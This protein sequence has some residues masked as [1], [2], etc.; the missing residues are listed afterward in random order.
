MKKVA[1]LLVLFFIPADFFAQLTV[2][3]SAAGRDNYIYSRGNLLYVAQ[4]VNLLKNTSGSDTE[5]SIYLRKEAQ[6][7]QGTSGIS[8]NT[9]DGKISVF[10]EGSS[11][12]YDYDYWASPVGENTSENGLFGLDL[13]HSPVNQTKS[14]KAEIISGL[15]G[16]AKPLQISSRWIYTYDGKNYSDWNFIGEKK[17]IP[18]GYGF[19][20]KGVNGI[21]PILV[22]GRENN[23][24]NSQRYDFRG[25]PN[26]GTI[27]IPVLEGQIVLVGNPYPSAL[28][29]SKFLLENS[30]S[31]SLTSECIGTITRKNA[32]TGI[33]YFWDS[34]ENG[35]SHYLKDYVGGYGAFSPVD[36]CTDGIYE[37]PIFI[38]YDSPEGTTTNLRGDYYERRYSPIGQGFMVEGAS[39]S[40][41]IFKNSQRVFKKE[42]E[43]SNP[44]QT[45]QKSPFGKQ[46]KSTALPKIQLEV[47]INDNY[48]RHLSLAFWKSATAGTDAAMDAKP[49]GSAATDVGFLH[50]DENFIID[51]RPFVKTDEIPLYLKV[52]E[53]PAIFKFQIV[54]T[55]NLEWKNFFLFDSKTGEYHSLSENPIE[56]S[57]PPGIYHNRFKLVFQKK[58]LETFTLENKILTEFDIFQNN[59][60]AQLEIRN[61]TLIPILSIGIYD[62][63]GRQLFYEDKLENKV[64]YSI[65]TAHFINS[66]YIVKIIK[67]N[68]TK[69]SKKITIL[70][71]R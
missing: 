36:P 2:K 15:E 28:D 59:D 34:Q 6:L 51:I 66:I 61:P 37:R 64:F 62:L 50:N 31:G 41:L 57:L 1:I 44:A 71:H 26:D 63:N 35:N 65:S 23:P 40:Q 48:V 21:D 16:N 55:E 18:P 54:N 11:N 45:T 8:K 42:D 20:M 24:G 52:E 14:L 46:K 39:N 12:A 9:G 70:D 43:T 67:K 29:L 27:E 7:I 17:A 25:K 68:Q 33:A 22:E 49:Y 32:I 69:I 60:T 56:I 53:T 3:P 58:S 4:E 5:A 19:T 13:L 10:Q 38:K 47:L 30:G